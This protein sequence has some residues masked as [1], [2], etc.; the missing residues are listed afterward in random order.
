MTMIIRTAALQDLDA[1]SHV[2]SQCFPPNEAATREQF[3]ER[4]THYAS[5]FW[6][7]FDD[8]GE[9]LI[10]FVDGFVTDE[11][12]LRD[13]MYAQ[14]E[15]HNEAGKWQMIFGVNTLPEYRNKGHAG[16][17]IRRMIHDAREQGR[18]GL[19]LTCKSEKVHYYASFGF[20]NEGVSS[21]IHGGAVWHQMRL[22]F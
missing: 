14:A 21:S 20:V 16:E 13:D 7:M 19:V 10:S 12:D 17:L 6:L 2:E 15:L 4:L 18:L 1:I 8:D 9:K 22:T 3:R 11:K 5:H